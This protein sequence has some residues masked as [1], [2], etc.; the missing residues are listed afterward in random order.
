MAKKEKEPGCLMYLLIIVVVA[1]LAIYFL[2][3]NVCNF[4]TILT[5]GPSQYFANI[6]HFHKDYYCKTAST[7]EIYEDILQAGS[8]EDSAKKHVIAKLKPGQ[9]FKLNGYKRKEYV[10]WVAANVANGSELIYG[11]F[12]VPDKIKMP[13]FWSYLEGLW[14]EPKPFYNKYFSEIPRKSTEEYRKGLFSTY[15]TKLRQTVKLKSATDPAE[16]QKIKESKEFKIIDGISSDT[17][18]Y[19]CPASDYKKAEA[20]WEAYL[21]NGFDTHYLQISAT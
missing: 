16:M 19:Y 3:S 10:T 11:Y 9:R 21:G 6:V 12:M 2:V 17:T 8:I 5:Y 13:T 1:I 18:V 4:K 15:K 7:H 20:L 14:E